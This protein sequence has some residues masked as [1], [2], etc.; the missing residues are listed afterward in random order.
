MISSPGPS[1]KKVSALGIDDMLAQRACR[2]NHA[3]FLAVLE[4]A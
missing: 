4:K 3:K 2:G 1:P